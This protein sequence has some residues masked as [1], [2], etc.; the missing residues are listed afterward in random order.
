M[1]AGVRLNRMTASCDLQCLN[2]RRDPIDVLP[3]TL[4]L[5]GPLCGNP[6]SSI[7]QYAGP[8]PILDLGGAKTITVEIVR[9]TQSMDPIGHSRNRNLSVGR[10]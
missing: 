8:T 9:N 4:F 10:F 2:A 5:D 1:E 7:S 3:T 6:W